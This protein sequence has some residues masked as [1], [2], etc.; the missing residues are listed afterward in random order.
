MDEILIAYCETCGN[1]IYEED[2]TV[3]VNVEGRYFDSV[4]CLMDYYDIAK[5]EV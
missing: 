4:D 1:P 5:V 3:Y 2:G